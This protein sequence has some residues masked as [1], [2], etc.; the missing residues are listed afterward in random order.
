MRVKCL[1]QEHNTM[2]LKQNLDV[3]VPKYIGTISLF[4]SR[5][6]AELTEAPLTLVRLS[7]R[8]QQPLNQTHKNAVLQHF[9]RDFKRALPSFKP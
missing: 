6:N 2:I 4:F 3:L 5:A 8:N 9:K 7:G 1:A